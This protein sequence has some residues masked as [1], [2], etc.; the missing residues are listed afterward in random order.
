MLRSLPYVSGVEYTSSAPPDVAF[1]IEA[2]CH[3]DTRVALLDEIMKWSAAHD[4]RHVFWLSG[5]AGTGKSTIARTVARR[6]ADV[7]R[8]G[9]SFFFTRGGGE[10]ASARKFATTVAVQ[11][12]TAL[13]ALKPRI[14]TAARA[15]RDVRAAAL[16]EQ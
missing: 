11:L 15:I 9:A 8:L 3:R 13:P 2:L 7:G 4:A 10:L 16:H 12:A 5:L 14:C 6:C 1:G